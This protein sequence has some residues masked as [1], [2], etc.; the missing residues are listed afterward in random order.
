MENFVADDTI[1]RE[2]EAPAQ[3]AAEGIKVRFNHQDMT[4]SPDDAVAYA[5]KGLKLD[6]LQ[7]LLKELSYLSALRGKS[8]LDT[9]REYIS[10]DEEIAK[11]Q[12]GEQFKDD[13]QGLEDALQKYKSDAEDKRN[14]LFEEDALKEREEMERN[15]TDE[16]FELQSTC[17]EIDS[18]EKIPKD[19]FKDATEMSLL[20]AYLRFFHREQ[21]KIK[22]EKE[23]QARNLKA[24][25]GELKG[26]G[27]GF[28]TL[29]SAFIK[30]LNS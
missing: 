9:V 8:A 30:G 19:V 17:P 10:L 7:P 28:D 25:A 5:Q 4:L 29:L 23:T 15:F 14:G 13:P 27:E 2:Q 6:S 26:G 18:F 24:A 21:T 1:Q 3:P 22:R 11:M 12:L 20:D 16:F